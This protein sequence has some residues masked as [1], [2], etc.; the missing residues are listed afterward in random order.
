MDDRQ[1]IERLRERIRSLERTAPLGLLLSAVVH[2]VNNPLS[3]ILIGADTLRRKA[4]DS[5]AV[6]HHL[7]VLEAQSAKIIEINRMLQGLSKRNLGSSERVDGAELIQA[8]AEVEVLLGGETCRPE[9]ELAE[10]PLPMAV[11]PQLTLQ[12]LRFLARSA[13]D[14]GGDGPLQVTVDRQDIPLIELPNIRKSP[15]REFVVF[16]IVV[17]DP[18]GHPVPITDWVGDF[19]GSQPSERTLELMASWEV[20]RK[21]PGR[22]RIAAGTAGAELTLM[23]PVLAGDAG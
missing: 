17:G 21:L 20:V 15:T 11:E 9:I 2:E 16:R 22:L 18:D 6:D 12:V 7:D 13:R 23:V 1:T 3:V 10:G 19:F 5:E 14:L 4:A 8:F